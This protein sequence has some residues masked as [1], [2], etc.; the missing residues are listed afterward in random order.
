MT[1]FEQVT[2]GAYR[3]T[4]KQSLPDGR[5]LSR[6]ASFTVKALGL[7]DEPTVENGVKEDGVLV[8][9]DG[10]PV[11]LNGILPENAEV[12]VTLTDKDGNQET[13]VGEADGII[14]D[15]TNGTWRFR[16]PERYIGQEVDVVVIIEDPVT[17]RKA[18]VRLRV[19]SSLYQP[20][21]FDRQRCQSVGGGSLGGMALWW[22][23]MLLMFG[24]RRRATLGR[25][26]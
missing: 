25:L 19:R 2:N 15:R 14:Y 18:I 23:L 11:V 5:M 8:V 21:D 6:E 26:Q 10:E 20:L 13:F 3:L 24:V 7:D 9:K 1:Q 22:G 12:T 4:I 17:K 16:L